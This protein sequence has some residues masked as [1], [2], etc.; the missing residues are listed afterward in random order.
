MLS[1][2]IRGRLH[3]RNVL[4]GGGVAHGQ[5]GSTKIEFIGQFSPSLQVNWFLKSGINF[6]WTFIWVYF[7][8]EGHSNC[9]EAAL[10]CHCS[11][12]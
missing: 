5:K 9:T 8:V 1:L 4:R 2:R 3:S 7:T 12:C 6:S 11:A 10:S